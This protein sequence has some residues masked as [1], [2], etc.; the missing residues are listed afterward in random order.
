MDFNIKSEIKSK[1]LWHYLTPGIPDHLFERLPGISMSKRVDRPLILSYL[2]LD[3]NLVVWDIGAGT[4]TVTIEVALLCPTTQVI[5]VERD[6]EI[7]ELIKKNCENFGVNN[8]TIVTGN[9]P[10]CLGENLP[11]PDR[12]C[13]EGTNNYK[14][15]LSEVWKR[16]KSYG[17]VV[18][19]TFTLQGIYEIVNTLTK[20]EA[21]NLE[22]VQLH[23]CQLPLS[24]DHRLST[25]NK[26]I[27]LISA[28]KLN[29]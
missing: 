20:L 6:E 13:I 2:Q 5:A 4:G 24:S 18:I 1:S 26:V 12:V 22:V 8:V 9:A 14:T 28:N 21:T 17:R 10:D 19:T 11:N 7:T 23:T 3:N 29:L 27:F 16:L 15:V 25:E